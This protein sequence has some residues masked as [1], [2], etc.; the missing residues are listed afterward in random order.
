MKKYI[1]KRNILGNLFGKIKEVELIES[2]IAFRD[3]KGNRTIVAFEELVD[4][5]VVDITLIGGRLTIKTAQKEYVTWCVSSEKRI[6]FS[7]KLHEYSDKYIKKSV[8]NNLNYFIAET[9]NKFLR[10]SSAIIIDEN[11]TAFMHSFKKSKKRWEQNIPASVLEVLTRYSQ[12]FPISAHIDTLRKNYTN[13]ILVSRKP[14]YDAIES[15]PLTEEQRI[16]VIQ[17]NDKNLVLAAAGTGKTSVMVA[18]ALDLIIHNKIPAENVLVL[19]Y[20]NAAAKE[21]KERI[22]LRIKEYGVMCDSPQIMTFHKLGLEIIK[23]I[24]GITQISV[25]TENSI[26]LEAWLSQWLVTYIGKSSMNMNNFIELAYQPSDPFL[27]ESQREYEAGIRDNQLRTINNELVKSYQEVLIANWL[28][29]NCVEYKYKNSYVPKRKSSLRFDHKPDFHI[30]G[31]NIY[32]EY[33]S[34]AIDGTTRSN[35]NTENYNEEIAHKIK[36]HEECGTVLLATYHYD[37]TEGNL[38]KR[39]TE[40]FTNAGVKLIPKTSKAIVEQLQTSDLLTSN[41]KRYVKCLQAIRVEQ[42][43]RTE[44]IERLQSSN[45]INAHLYADFLD[46]LVTAYINE[47]DRQHCID[48]DDMIIRANEAVKTGT[49]T[50]TWTDILVDEFQDISSTRMNLLNSL[51]DKGDRPR[52][53]A[54]GDDWQSI[55]RFSGSKLALI[56]QFE[57]FHGTYSLSSLQKTFRYNNSIAKTAGQF[58][59]QNPEQYKK[60]IVT[61]THVDESQIYLLDSDLKGLPSKVYDVVDKIRA[62]DKSGSIAILA[63][64]RYLLN[65]TKG[66]LNKANLHHNIHYW[67]LHGSKGLEAD[68]CIIIGFIR[69]KMGF[70][71][72]NK[73]EAVIDALLP[74]TDSYKHSEERRLLYVAITRAKHKSYLIADPI[75]PSVFIT[76]LLS[77]SYDIHIFSDK[78]K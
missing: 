17:N 58:V 67:T 2:A 60:N 12:Y 37:W 40:L 3:K 63:R 43:N 65:E 50:P 55:Y 25:F 32:L 70:P 51:I 41:V 61:H 27:F 33:F 75:A 16:A 5:P 44:I 9:Q 68:Y 47:L 20:N 52:L 77:P 36:I 66:C 71:N 30:V 4:F 38:D 45:I 19:A 31:T 24:G 10:D 76:E 11:F 29:L 14:F 34:I 72:E 21:L 57:K 13:K 56:T 53:T 74:L 48:F 46:E 54:V 23:A 7:E 73:E 22:L 64:Y 6:I 62:H 35:I 39:L 8:L 26:K 59:M 15:N 1:L 18:K 69:G 78:F 42:L 28:F 49:F